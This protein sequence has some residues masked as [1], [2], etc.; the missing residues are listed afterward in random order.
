MAGV[1]LAASA[2]TV[3]SRLLLLGLTPVGCFLGFF[4]FDFLAEFFVFGVFGLAAFALVV[5]FFGFSRFVVPFFL[6]GF[7]FVF[8]GGGDEGTSGGGWNRQ[9]VRRGGRG[10]QQQRG[11]Q[12]DQQV[13]EFPHRPFIGGF[14][15]LR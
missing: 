6:V 14:G 11:E 2:F 4:G 8:R 7:G 3:P 5:A 9:R 10:E 1:A 12:Q 15:G 13:R